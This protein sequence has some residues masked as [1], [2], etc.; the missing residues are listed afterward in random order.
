MITLFDYVLSGNCY[1]V[2]LLA[3]LL[4]V[5]LECEAVDFH[6]GKAHRL[7]AFRQLNPL[8]ELPVIRDEDLVLR[9]A[10]AILVHLAT[11]YDETGQWYPVREAGP[12]Q[13][14]LAFS[15]QITRTASAARLHDMLGYPLDIAAARDGAN[16]LFRVLDDHLNEREIESNKW[17]VGDHP[18]IADIACFPYVAMAEDGGISLDDY[19]AIRH[20]IRH[21]KGLDK[22]IA[23]PGISMLF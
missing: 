20:W 16:R 1:K 8:G 15:E 6:P 10:Q 17:L 11:R 4:D 3:S 5:E 7:E 9:D 19:G 22:F 2:R 12:V 14:W 18:T 23:M 13:Q 21:V